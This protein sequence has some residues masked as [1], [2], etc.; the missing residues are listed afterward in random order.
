MGKH[1]DDGVPMA[2]NALTLTETAHKRRASK[3]S[4]AW[5]RMAVEHVRKHPGASWRDVAAR[6]GWVTG[7]AIK[8]C[9]DALADGRLVGELEALQCPE[10]S[11]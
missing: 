9:R 6:H 4:A 5:A 8:A 10:E 2:H 11:A 7:R 1:R 3:Q